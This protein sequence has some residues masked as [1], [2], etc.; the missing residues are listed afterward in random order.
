M[1]EGGRWE[2]VREGGRWEGVREEGGEKGKVRRGERSEEGEDRWEGAQCEHI[3]SNIRKV[4]CVSVSVSVSVCV[5]V[6]VCVCV[7]ILCTSLYVIPLLQFIFS[8]FQLFTQGIHVHSLPCVCMHACVCMPMLP[9]VHYIVSR[10]SPYLHVA[11]IA[12]P[13]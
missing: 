1:K 8:Q 7:R 3:R 6:C 12:Q 4:V 2:G 10:V 11:I 5:C 9:C 13:S